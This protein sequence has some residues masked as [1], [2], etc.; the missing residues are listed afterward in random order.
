MN[1]VGERRRSNSNPTTAVEPPL[2]GYVWVALYN[3]NVCSAFII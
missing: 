2:S 3:I 1:G